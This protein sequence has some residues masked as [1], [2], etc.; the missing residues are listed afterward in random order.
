LTL[1]GARAIERCDTIVCDYLASQ[2]IVDLAPPDCE[3]IYVGK[4]AGAHTLTQTEI[5]ALIVKLALDG[6]KVVRLKGGDVFVFA[7][8]GEEAQALTAAGVPFE[9]VPGITSA[10]AAP[11]YAGIPVTHRDHNTSFSISTGHEDP[12]KGYT[13]L[14]YAKLAN[15][16]ATTI[17]LMAMG[18]LPGIVSA[19]LAN[20]IAETM[21]VAIV[22][23]GTKPTQETLVATLGTIVDEVE[24]TR[25]AAP[26]IVV[27][28]TVVN[29][30][31]TIRWFDRAPLFG[32][33][34]LVMR[35]KMQ[36]DAFARELWEIGA[37]PILAPTIA[38][39][40]PDDEA[41]ALAAVTRIRDYAWVA[42][43]SRNGVD[44]FFDRLG[45]SGKDTRAF[46]DVKVAAIG[47]ATAAA[48]TARGIRVDFMP[49]VY[50]NEAV[51]D[52]L[53][54]RTATGD[55]VLVF[56]AQEARDVLPDTLRAAGRAVD[57]VAAYKTRFVDDADLRERAERADI[58]TFTSSSTVEGLVR[59]IADAATL[60]AGKTVA[61]IGPI[62]AATARAYGIRVDVIAAEFT[63][64]G[65]VQ[66]LERGVTA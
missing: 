18:N 38:I 57:V 17:F 10:I 7:R 39:G 20:G 47:P 26:A 27:V 51:A 62:T 1:K 16:K 29:E 35:P 19:L 11:A 30:R 12:L 23:E 43:A 56:R 8:G 58:I 2:A 4:K 48:L 25:F 66:A 41:A 5:T 55:R 15:P 37:E 32:K 46:G 6:K 50:V 40:P 3:R 61:A 36:A 63:V 45:A 54:A 59:N 65:L 49:D 34:V 22:R 14:D 21:P 53:V 13:S 31:E 60:L 33:R 24:R 42:F 64:D 52:G 44:A 28:G 9:I